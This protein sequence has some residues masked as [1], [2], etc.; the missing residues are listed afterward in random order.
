MQGFNLVVRMRSPRHFMARVYVYPRP[1][2]MGRKGYGS[3]EAF[4]RIILRYWST[5][6]T[7]VVGGQQLYVELESA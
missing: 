7:V 6:F 3:R 5:V 4:S 1:E 2:G